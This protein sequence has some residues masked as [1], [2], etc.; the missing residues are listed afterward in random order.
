M[1]S[2]LPIEAKRGLF[3]VG[4]R[5][6]ICLYIDQIERNP[7]SQ[8][9]IRV[10]IKQIYAAVALLITAVAGLF[11]IGGAELDNLLSTFTGDPGACPP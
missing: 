10:S 3:A 4:A 11:G 9:K 1:G 8:P 2:T 7:V 5:V 6:R